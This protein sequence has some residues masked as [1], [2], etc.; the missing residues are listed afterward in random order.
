MLD[1]LRSGTGG[2]QRHSPLED[3][4]EDRIRSICTQSNYNLD[5]G[6]NEATYF[7]RVERGLGC[8][9]ESWDES[10]ALAVGI[11]S[12]LSPTE[13]FV[14]TSWRKR[15]R[16]KGAEPRGDIWQDRSRCRCRA[17]LQTVRSKIPSQKSNAPRPRLER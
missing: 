16:C 10:W 12:S 5:S 1:Q 15:A 9:D 2:P 3:E 13:Q 14:G 7:Q 11:R 8:W 17:A 6:P 4:M